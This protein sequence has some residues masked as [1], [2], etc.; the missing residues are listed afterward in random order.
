[1]IVLTPGLIV[2]AASASS[3]IRR[4][5]RSLTDPPAL[6]NSHLATYTL[7]EIENSWAE[8]L[9]TNIGPTKFAFETFLLGNAVDSDERSLANILQNV[10][11]DLWSRTTTDTW[12]SW[13]GNIA[14][15][16][17]MILLFNVMITVRRNVCSC[18]HTVLERKKGNV[19][20]QLQQLKIYTQFFV[21]K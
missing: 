7:Y 15:I 6:K 11:Q 13:S 19:G 18:W 4:A 12:A 9:T 2:P 5:I 14:R 16:A 10:V 21:I 3:I 17:V 20:S 8:S 1:M